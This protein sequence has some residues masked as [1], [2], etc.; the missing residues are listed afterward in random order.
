MTSA[1]NV[2][3]APAA[4]ETFPGELLQPGEPGYDQARRVHN[5][6]IDKRPA[7][8]ARCFGAADVIAAVKLAQALGLET[9]IRA[10]GHNVAGRATVDGGVMIDL[11]P[12]KAIAVDTGR[13]TAR[14]EAGVT[15]GELNAATQAHG[16]AV[17]GGV[18]S[19]TGVAGLTLG[20]GLGW[21]MGKFGLAL[22]NL[23]TVELVTA[24][25]DL[26]RASASEH[27]D[28]FW[29]IR[30]GGGNFGVATSF[31][32]QLH[33]VGPIVT[34]G[35]VAQPFAVAGEVLRLYRDATAD[36]PDEQ[37]IVAGLIHAPDGSGAKL[38]AL[39]SCHCG[40]PA[41]GERAMQ[42]LRRMGPAAV[43]T[44][45]PMAYTDLNA[46][47]DGAYPK[48]ALNYWKSSFLSTLSD[49]AIDTMV[50][51]FAR[52]P[53]P[54]GQIIVEHLHGA[55]TRVPVGDTAFPHRAAGYNF[56]LISQWTD[57]AASTDC[58]SWARDTYAAMSGFTAAGRYV[59]YLDSDES[60]DPVAAAYGPNYRRL[61]QVK[62]RYD[63]KNFFRLNQNIV[64]TPA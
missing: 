45:G 15:W 36:L 50:E 13:R 16:L 52:C 22:D 63:P 28:L 41:D 34:G 23:L 20:G 30:G 25:G 6:L 48:G 42:E 38:A 19:S 8:I 51:C 37:S 35:L 31:E 4:L 55:A 12:M 5:G 56:L 14:V 57:P 58:I 62:R 26:V 21:L 27:P 9:A 64:P 53:A 40:P 49:A 10:G 1:F 29:A 43:D 18:V 3:G 47:M 54:M 24:A 60:G 44:L 39:V 7:L 2:A 46:M 59:N 33:A 32:F 11:S 17:T 61:Q